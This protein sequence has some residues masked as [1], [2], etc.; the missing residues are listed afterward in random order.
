METSGKKQEQISSLCSNEADTLTADL[1][2]VLLEVQFIR[3][4]PLWCQ[5]A[6]CPLHFLLLLATKTLSSLLACSEI[7]NSIIQMKRVNTTVRRLVQG[8]SA[9]LL[10]AAKVYEQRVT[11]RLIYHLFG[12]S[13]T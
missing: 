5:Y 1:Y 9:C 4:C 7:H 8:Q 3:R 2:K 10:S 13:M 12:L 6:L 11:K